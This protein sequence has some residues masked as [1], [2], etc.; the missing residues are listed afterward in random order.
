MLDHFGLVPTLRRVRRSSSP[1]GRCVDRDRERAVG[2]SRRP[3]GACRWP[4]PA[5]CSGRP[6]SWSS[7][8]PSATAT[9]PGGGRHRPL[10]ADGR[11]AGGGEVRVR[12][13]V[14]DDGGGFD[15]AVATAPHRPGRGL[16]LAG[17]AE[18][19]AGPGRAAA[20]GERAGPRVAGRCWRCRCGRRESV[21]PDVTCPNVGMGRVADGE[22]RSEV[23]RMTSL[24]VLIADDHALVRSGIRALLESSPRR[25]RRR[26]GRRRPPGGRDGPGRWRRGW[27]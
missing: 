15:P 17:I 11:L 9:G 25:G 6:K 23:S 14:D 27:C 7:A 26:R 16:G 4:S 5:T 12:V 2:A 1:A 13:V 18:R 21:S 3:P 20:A 19:L 24:N 10:D 8:T 22:W